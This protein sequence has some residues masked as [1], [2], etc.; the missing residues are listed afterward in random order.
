MPTT[1]LAD[2]EEITGYKV[3]IWTGEAFRV[4]G[5]T[6]LVTAGRKFERMVPDFWSEVVADGRLAR[7][8]AASTVQPW[9]LGLSS[10]D[11]ECKKHGFRY[12]ICIEETEHT[13]FTPLAQEYSLF[14]KQIGASDW[15]CFELPE[16]LSPNGPFWRDDPYK[17]MGNL[18]YEFHDAPDHSLGLHFDAYPPSHRFGFGA[19]Y[20]PKQPIEF[21]LSVKKP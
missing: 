8:I 15:M 12:T 20:D 7:L 6:L 18:G 10:W 19:D 5:F 4:V 17:M 21:W 11:P 1:Y 2:S 13:D 3:K 14:R 16:D 9:V